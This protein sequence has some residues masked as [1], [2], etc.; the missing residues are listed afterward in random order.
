MTAS[1]PRSLTMVYGCDMTRWENEMSIRIHLLLSDAAARETVT[2]LPPGCVRMPSPHAIEKIR[3]AS[4]SL[5]D[6]LRLSRHGAA[7][8]IGRQFEVGGY[9]LPPA[10]AL[11]GRSGPRRGFSP[12]LAR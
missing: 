1:P 9:P 3:P 4:C 2:T 11:L 5:R 7:P 6:G 12:A 8:G 10:V